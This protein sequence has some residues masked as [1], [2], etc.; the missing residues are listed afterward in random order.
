MDISELPS[1]NSVPEHKDAEN[2]SIFLE[3]SGSAETA[4][5]FS[6]WDLDGDG[7][8]SFDHDIKKNLNLE[9]S[10][11]PRSF[12]RML[13]ANQDGL[14]DFEDF[15]ENIRVLSGK[16]MN[17]KIR[18]LFRFFG[19][20]DEE[21]LTLEQVKSAVKVRGNGLLEMLG[22]MENGKMIEGKKLSLEELNRIFT[23]SETGE[24]AIN[25]FCSALSTIL[26]RSKSHKSS[27]KVKT[28]SISTAY[29]FV[30]KFGAAI[31]VQLIIW[32]VTYYMYI[33][34]G[35][36]VVYGI[37][38]GFGMN[39][40][41]VTVALLMT[42]LHSMKQYLHGMQA[43]QPLIPMHSNIELHSFL[44]FAV[45][46]HSLGHGAAQIAN[47]TIYEGFAYTV[48]APAMMSGS[49]S[50]E[51]STSGDGISGYLLLSLIIVMVVTALM[52]N[53]NSTMYTL[54]RRCHYLHVVWVGLIIIHVPDLLYVIYLCAAVMA[55]FLLDAL[56]KFVACTIGSTLRRSRTRGQVSYI[57]VKR[58]PFQPPPIPGCYYRLMVPAVS[59]LEW[60]PFS[61]ASSCGSD[62]LTFMVDSV[63]DWTR[64]VHELVNDPVKR[65]TTAVYVQ[66]PFVTATQH[67]VEDLEGG[68]PVMI[69]ASGVGITPFLSVM[70]TKVTDQE[71]IESS[72]RV[73]SALFR[74]KL[75]A[76][77]K[78]SF[79]VLKYFKDLS[80]LVSLGGEAA[81]S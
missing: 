26:E 37:A 38:K 39:V 40:Y 58:Q 28:A 1:G 25:S 6:N 78:N 50:W 65:E 42:M 15:N 57:S 24:K 73:F 62:H 81:A 63:G 55:M 23:S 30:N 74:E 11:C 46:F 36:P 33:K 21:S 68:R 35:Y 19:A 20:C 66:G 80:A 8:L 60:H 17:D 51:R 16:K 3:G 10:F 44:G 48:H 77:R 54:F 22:F 5:L 56:Y 31:T 18:L 49:S 2:I 64:K 59:L 43:F 52:R 76:V 41:L 79:F 53:M 13:D 4:K 69:V 7:L 72:K 61:L 45:F 12:F 70:A 71:A 75:G 47:L 34:A 14:V 29:V 67:A 27:T 32:I 9:D